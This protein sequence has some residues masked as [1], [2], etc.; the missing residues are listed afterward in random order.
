MN[1]NAIIQRLR[2]TRSVFHSEDD[3]K[4]AMAWA[5]SQ[6]YPSFQVRLEKPIEIGMRLKD[7][8]ATARAPIDIVILDPVSRNAYPIEI[9][10]KTKKADLRV[11][12]ENYSLANHG[13]NLGARYGFRKDIY[14]VENVYIENYE[15]KQGFTFILTNDKA[16]YMNDV[17]SKNSLDAFFTFH[18]GAVLPKDYVGW[19]Y[20]NLAKDK[21][22]FGLDPDVNPKLKRH[23]TLSKE[24]IYQLDL[25]K[26][27]LIQWNDYSNLQDNN[28]RST[29]FKY[30]LVQVER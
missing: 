8:D 23:W 24:Y 14:R 20:A 25:N 12:G 13:A 15:I 11:E 4:L 6:L 28:G 17:S 30:C 2:E 19:N 21:Y 18:H 3:L 29:D 7:G 27:Y 10:Y 16:Y 22:D 1:F 9:K 26:E 5:I